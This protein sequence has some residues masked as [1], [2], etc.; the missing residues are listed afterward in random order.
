M[1]T[2]NV[3]ASAQ[4]GSVGVSANNAAPSA[5]P[6]KSLATD[7]AVNNC[8][9]AEIRRSRGTTE[10]IKGCEALLARAAAMPR[11]KART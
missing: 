3:T 1:D 8:P 10:V 6:T 5:G 7:C 11:P 2:A 4:N 9:F